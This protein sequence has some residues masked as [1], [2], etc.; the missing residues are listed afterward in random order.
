MSN[1]RTSTRIHEP[2]LLISPEPAKRPLLRATERHVRRR[3]GRKPFGIET[4][5][6]PLPARRQGPSPVTPGEASHSPRPGT[7][8]PRLRGTPTVAAQMRM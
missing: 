3:F 1:Q 5:L 8:R 2:L 7:P 6:C 4:S